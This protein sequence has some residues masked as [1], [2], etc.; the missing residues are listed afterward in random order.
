MANRHD[1]GLDDLF[2]G[3]PESTTPVPSKTTPRPADDPLAELDEL[4]S[5]AER[6]KVSVRPETPRSAPGKRSLERSRTPSGYAMP[7][8]NRNSIDTKRPAASAPPPQKKPEPVYAPG[9]VEE[10]SGG[11]W[12]WGSLWN[13]ATTAV[14]AAEGI[15][16][17]IQQSEE[18][19]KWVTQVKGNA[20]ALRGLGGYYSVLRSRRGVLT[21]RVD[22]WRCPLQGIAHICEPLESSCASDFEPRAA[23]YPYYARSAELPICRY[24][25]VWRL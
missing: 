4:E 1:D 5:L 15:V 24:R 8:S 19:K 16:Q 21:G 13:T 12:G 9:P 7:V 11:G 25:S 10:N 23:A 3:L 20:D 14:K 22:S 17:E 18:G 2:A 6:P